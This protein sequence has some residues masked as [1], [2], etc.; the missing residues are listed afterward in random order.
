MLYTEPLEFLAVTM[1]LM[2]LPLS[3]LLSFNELEVFPEITEH[4]ADAA[5]FD[6]SAV[7]PR[8]EQR[9]QVYL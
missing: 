9:Y 6:F 4:L 5:G 7:L 1:T 3:D 8:T 2:Y